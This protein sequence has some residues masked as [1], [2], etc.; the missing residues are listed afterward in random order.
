MRVL[1]TEKP[2]DSM[3]GVSASVLPDSMPSVVSS[4]EGAFT[5]RSRELPLTK[6]SVV[7]ASSGREPSFFR[8]T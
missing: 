4:M 8:S 7:P 6:E 3:A 1:L 2:A 5:P